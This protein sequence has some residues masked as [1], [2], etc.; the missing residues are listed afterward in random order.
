MGDVYIVT[1]KDPSDIDGDITCMD[2]GRRIF[3]YISELYPQNDIDDAPFNGI[4]TDIYLNEI[5]S[6]PLII[7]DMTIIL[8][9][10]DVLHIVHRPSGTERGCC[11]S[12]MLAGL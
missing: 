8:S 11:D 9:D 4:E 7:D 1:H 10:G 5:T 6:S 3:D 12:C 2:S